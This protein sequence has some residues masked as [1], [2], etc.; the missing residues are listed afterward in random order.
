MWYLRICD[1]WRT[2]YHAVITHIQKELI[3]TIFAF[4]PFEPEISDADAKNFSS[5]FYFVSMSIDLDVQAFQYVEDACRLAWLKSTFHHMHH[6]SSMKIY[7]ILP[8]MREALV[9]TSDASSLVGIILFF[10]MVRGELNAGRWLSVHA[11]RIPARSSFI[12]LP[13]R[14]YQVKNLYPTRTNVCAGA[15]VARGWLK[16]SGKPLN[17]N[18]SGVAPELWAGNR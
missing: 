10:P 3:H 1:T 15:I 5:T 2:Y 4:L 16:S 11:T 8:V 17:E 14:R 18:L 13:Q 12:L 7:G 6:F 9:A